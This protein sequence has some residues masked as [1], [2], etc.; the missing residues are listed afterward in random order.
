M[1]EAWRRVFA[2][3]WGY[4]DAVADVTR[5][6]IAGRLTP[7]GCEKLIA[8]LDGVEDDLPA[9]AGQYAGEIAAAL[10]GIM[11]M[12]ADAVAAAGGSDRLR[13]AGLILRACRPVLANHKPSLVSVCDVVLADVAEQLGRADEAWTLQAGLLAAGTGLSPGE[14][15]ELHNNQATTLVTQGRLAEAVR[16]YDRALALGADALPAFERAEVRKN[17][18]V[19]W[20]SLGDLDRAAAEC[21]TALEYAR[22]HGRPRTVAECYRNLGQAFYDRAQY[23]EAVLAFTEAVAAHE[24]LGPHAGEA[25]ARLGRV[26]AIKRLLA[27]GDLPPGII[28]AGLTPETVRDDC[29][30]EQR[31][32]LAVLR[33]MGSPG[34]V[35]RCQY[36]LALGL[37]ATGRHGEALE[38]LDGLRTDQFDALDRSKFL[39]GRADCL[40]A[41]GKAEAALA[42]YAA[43]R[44]LL[45]GDVGLAGI[46]ETA[47]EFVAR[48]QHNLTREATTALGLGR[49][50]AAYEVALSGKGVLF[51]RL[52]RPADR[53]ACPVPAE[54]APVRERVVAALRADSGD[55][56]FPPGLEQA[57][58][59][60]VRSWAQHG[61]AAADRDPIPTGGTASLA[62]VRAALP[63]DWAV[64]DFLCTAPEEVTA[65]VVTRDRPLVVERLPFPHLSPGLGDRLDRLT[66]SMVGTGP[67]DD[68]AGL[69]DLDALLFAPLRPHL[70]GV[71]GLYLV[72]HNHLHAYPLDAARRRVEGRVAYLADEFE[73]A[74]LPAAGLLPGLPQPA[75][76]DGVFSVANP[77]RGRADSLPFADWEAARLKRFGGLDGAYLGGDS[78]VA[79]G[80]AGWGRASLVHFS[81]HGTGVPWFFP[82]A[83]LHLRDG[84]VLAHDVLHHLPPVRD[85]SVVVLNGC[86][87]GVRD[88]RAV[89]EGLG[90][91]AA[92]LL[93]GAG[94]VLATRWRVNDCC[95]AELAVAFVNYWTAGAGPA[96][97]LQLARNKVRDLTPEVVLDRCDEVFGDLADDEYAAERAALRGY[98]ARAERAAADPGGDPGGDDGLPDFRHPRYWAAFQY[99]GRAT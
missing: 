28:P 43:S 52:G 12:H 36:G 50:E 74:Y 72:P 85:G 59:E 76:Q 69:D 16:E 63:T 81:G 15:A 26:A 37:S 31:G 2:K 44:R 57:R 93:R 41:A 1:I 60:Y 10:A 6:D 86:E 91:M 96:K 22:D 62:D 82:F 84:P 90:L 8:T 20:L 79:A 47:L 73:T 68:D 95:A 13:S 98:A 65:F 33:D 29:L 23:G 11:V 55:E 18:A 61:R 70:A 94:G 78:A 77:G 58:V 64:V 27:S 9:E 4:D 88:Q 51:A 24:R 40:L 17:Q 42:A 5:P 39:A 25:H 56:V 35:A 66:K 53:P 87:T 38:L 49:P 3:M 71:R 92:F 21:Y 83:H 48:R 7:A 75:W 89:D 14:R 67:A 30:V 80:L 34:E 19:L 46:D 99:V 32:C 97:A 45:A 54:F